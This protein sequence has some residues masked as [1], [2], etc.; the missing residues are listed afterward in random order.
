MHHVYIIHG[1]GG[2]LY[3]GRTDNLDKRLR[4]DNN[5]QVSSTRSNRPW[6]YVYVESYLAKEDAV[7]RELTFKQYG[8]ART[9]VKKRINKSMSK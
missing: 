2:V 9:Y 3:F 5:G 6:R 4:E 1:K 8:N 7:D